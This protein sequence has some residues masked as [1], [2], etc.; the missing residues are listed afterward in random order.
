M[1]KE[2]KETCTYKGCRRSPKFAILVY[3]NVIGNKEIHLC[4][5]HTKQCKK[6]AADGIFKILGIKNMKT[7]G[8]QTNG[9]K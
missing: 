8:E 1:K 2:K 6:I 5:R 4:K 9:K 3:R 7:G